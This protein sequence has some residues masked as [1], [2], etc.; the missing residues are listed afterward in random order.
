[1]RDLEF[2]LVRKD[3]STFPVLINATAVYDEQGRF[4]ASRSTAFDNTERKRA[5]QALRTSEETLRLANTELVRAMRMK[6]E[7][8]ASMSHE[9][10]TPLHGILAVTETLHDQVI[11][12]LNE[13]QQKSVGLIEQSGRHLLVLINDLLDLSK[14][15]AGKLELHRSTVSADEV[16]RA[17][18]L[19]VREMAAKKGIEVDY[20]NGTPGVQ[21][22]ADEQ[23]LKQIL[24]NLVGNAVKFTPSGG[25]VRLS[26]A[27]EPGTPGDPGGTP[28]AGLIHFTVQDDGPGIPA[29]AQARLFQ[30]FIQLDAQLSR[31]HEG[32]GLGLALVKRLAEHHGGTVRLDSTGVQGEGCRFTIT[33]PLAPAP[34]PA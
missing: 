15:E 17:S 7:F 2:D 33:L 4:V 9:L 1:M 3:G 31:E 6:D 5:E 34:S 30:P 29:A 12:P 27:V 16:C 11:G 25:H 24:V 19:F 18:L 28:T 21:F 10:R 8:L 14:I 26:V 20:A 23:R 13:R 32:T 22:A